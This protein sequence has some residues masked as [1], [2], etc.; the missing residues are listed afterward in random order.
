[1]DLQLLC[2]SWMTVMSEVVYVVFVCERPIF[3]L[4]PKH[5]P[6]SRFGLSR[7][8]LAWTRSLLWAKV[9]F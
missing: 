7:S 6:L 3:R 1:M 9:L 4:D 5:F 2:Y 8:L